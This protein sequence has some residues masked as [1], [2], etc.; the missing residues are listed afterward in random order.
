[1][2]VCLSTVSHVPRVSTALQNN[3]QPYISLLPVT[4]SCKGLKHTKRLTILPAF[5]RKH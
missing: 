5:Q 2:W 4:V 3:E 1:M